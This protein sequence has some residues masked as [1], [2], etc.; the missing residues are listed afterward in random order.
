MFKWLKKKL[1]KHRWR[2][3]HTNKWQH[4][5]KQECGCGLNRC[6]EY[7]QNK[8]EIKGMPW[9]QGR[10]VWSNGEESKYYMNN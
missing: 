5:T 3:T 1:H 9:N 10:W 6:F 8:D 2:T 7:Y 4:S